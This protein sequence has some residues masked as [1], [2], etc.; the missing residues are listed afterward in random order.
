MGAVIISTHFSMLQLFQFISRQRALLLFVLLEGVSIWLY[1]RYNHYANAVYFNTSNY[2]VG[3][4]RR[5]QNALREYSNLATENAR[6]ATENAQLHQ[7]VAAFRARDWK[8]THYKADSLVMLRYRSTVAKVIKPDFYDSNNIITIDK[9]LADGIK[10]GMGVI[11]STG[12]VGKVKACSE[13]FSTVTTILSKYY[14][15]SAKIK[16]NSEIG[17][18][19]WLGKDSYTIQ[20][21]DVSRFKSVKL[22]DTVMTSDFNA[23]FPPNIMVGLV[24]KLGI[25]EDQAHHDI[26]L[27]LATDFRNLF[28]VYIIENKLLAEQ[29]AL[30][31]ETKASMKR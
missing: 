13:H 31:A 19:R 18:V 10:P 23:V 17:T 12:V 6:L 16:R 4:T 22:K 15:L 25:T 5:Y 28:Y 29:E 7:Q 11:S 14:T 27:Q 1:F 20:M 9:G 30:E 26:Q 2:Y 8:P 24:K 3:Q 21:E